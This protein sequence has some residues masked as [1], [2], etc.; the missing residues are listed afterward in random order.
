MVTVLFFGWSIVMVTT[1]LRH[2]CVVQNNGRGY[3]VLFS[4]LHL[5][6]KQHISS[7]RLTIVFY[8]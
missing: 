4:C 6:P 2:V 5:N 1:H 8:F 3:L 7:Q